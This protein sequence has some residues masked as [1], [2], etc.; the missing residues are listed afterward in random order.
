[1]ARPTKYNKVIIQKI[2]DALKSGSSRL[3]AAEYVGIAY[4]TFRLWKC[5]REEFHCLVTQAEAEAE[6]MFT[7][8]IAK[9]ARGHDTGSTTRTVKTVF[10]PRK[11]TMPDGSIIDELVPFQDVTETTTSGH[12][13]DWRAALEWLKRRRRE[14]WGDKLD[15]SKLPD[16]TILRLVA[17]EE[18]SLQDRI[19]GQAVQIKLTPEELRK[20][21]FDELLKI[22]KETLG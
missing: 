20:L 22:H 19:P 10:K 8:V 3:A 15:L 9:A 2:V 11:T 4:E 16:E 18:G 14:E 12:E 7:A 21:P 13:F 1:M 5:N 6:V 17:L